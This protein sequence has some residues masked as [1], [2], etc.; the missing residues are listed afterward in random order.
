[1]K[2]LYV[3]SYDVTNNHKRNQVAKLLEAYGRRVQYS[4]FECVLSKDDFSNLYNKLINIDIDVDMDSIIFYCIC[5]N[6][7]KK[8][9][10]VGCKHNNFEIQDDA[11]I[12]L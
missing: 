2:T 5:S 4:V 9:I 7:R 6:C 10:T 11:I 12:I 1:M 8:T 3:I